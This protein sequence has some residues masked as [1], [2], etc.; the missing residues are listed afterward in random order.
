MAPH[1]NTQ[2][3]VSQRHRPPAPCRPPPNAALQAHAKKVLAVAVHNHYKR[4]EHEKEARARQAAV[5][6][7]AQVRDG[8][9]GRLPRMCSCCC[10]FHSG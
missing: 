7:A 3:L 4:I 5:A 1:A 2:L 9:Q 6:A 10:L 8:R